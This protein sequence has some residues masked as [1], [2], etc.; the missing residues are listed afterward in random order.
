MDGIHMAGAVNLSAPEPLPN[1]DF[2]REC[3]TA[4]GVP[5]GI[6]STVTLIRL[7]AHVMNSEAGLLL[8]SRWALPERLLQVGFTFQYPEWA[9]AITQLVRQVQ[10]H[11]HARQ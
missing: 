3:R 5:V 6:P 9:G 4:W 2:L 7:G 10:A 11:G 1:H 8:K